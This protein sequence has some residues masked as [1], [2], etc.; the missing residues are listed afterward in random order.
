MTCNRRRFF[1]TLM[2]L[3]I[4]S[5]FTALLIRHQT[6][7]LHKFSWDF[8]SLIE[9]K[10]SRTVDHT[11]NKTPQIQNA[12]HTKPSSVIKNKLYYDRAHPPQHFEMWASKADSFCGGS[13]I[14]YNHDVAL[15]HNVT[16]DSSL[17]IGNRGGEDFR[18]LWKQSE[19]KEFFKFRKGFMKIV[20]E[21]VPKYDFELPGK[22]TP[23]NDWMRSMEIQKKLPNDTTVIPQYYIAVRR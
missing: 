3:V 5:S 2:V 14:G 15:L 8:D 12:V 4:L 23:L 16:V 11:H 22:K 19:D 18:K 21:K 10:F 20:C 1:V 6:H 9:V 13:Y 7:E 17:T